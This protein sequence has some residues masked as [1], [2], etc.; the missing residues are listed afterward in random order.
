MHLR[1]QLLAGIAFCAMV[2]AATAEPPSPLHPAAGFHIETIAHVGDARELAVLPNGDLLVGTGGA[3]VAIVPLAEGPGP[4]QTFVSIDD[5][6]DS[7]VAFSTAQHAIFVAGGH[8]IYRIPYSNGDRKA[9]ST[10]IRIATVRSG[11]PAPGSDGD[12][13]GTTSLAFS[14]RSALLYVSSGSSCNACREVD[15]TR[16][17][18]EQMT[19]D[20]ARATTRATR[21]R[22]GIALTIDPL[23]GHLWVGDAG[24]DDLPIGHPYEFLDDVSS[25]TGIA[26]YGWPQCEE[27]H[28]AYVAGARCAATVI[29][30]I[31]FPAYST[32]IAAAFYPEHP[33]VAH[34][35]PREFRG[36]IFVTR[37][38][39]WHKVAGCN[40]PPEVDF[41]P[42]SGAR[43]SIG[44]DWNDPTK[45]W[46]AFVSGF[47]PGCSSSTRIGRPT[48]LAVT[49]DGALLIADD[50]T[51]SIYRI[52]P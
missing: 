25:H 6:P 21:I 11:L 14:E 33:G 35:F 29:P 15:S 42:M 9:Q 17:M 26:D 1:W 27:N 50:Q 13:H 20:G 43:P 49:H 39:S 30:A 4:A 40:V 31:E 28:V 22:N 36:G 44:V 10:P 46:H 34:A 23:D 41:V 32:L 37:H 51:G 16:A 7:G 38:G 45:Q 12:N 19:G 48:G 52:E 24:Q 2:T 47:Q 3:T 8:G 18:I 5:P